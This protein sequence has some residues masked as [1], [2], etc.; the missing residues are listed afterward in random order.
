MSNQ[1]NPKYY[2]F[3]NLPQCENIQQ[4]LCSAGPGNLRSQAT[5]IEPVEMFCLADLIDC[6]RQTI[7][8]GDFRKLVK[9]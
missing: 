7:Q 5:K 1:P 8:Y 4:A 2:P 9:F 6:D 3:G